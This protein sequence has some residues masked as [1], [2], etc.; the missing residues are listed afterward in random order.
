LALTPTFFR[1][2][3]SLSPSL[4]AKNLEKAPEAD[5]DE[6]LDKLAAP[7]EMLGAARDQ[8]R[9]VADDV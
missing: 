6:M 7:G 3:L 5:A 1:H 9:G 8:D 2:P 4:D